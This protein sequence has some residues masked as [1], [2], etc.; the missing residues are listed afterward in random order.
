[1]FR[2]FPG[3][4]LALLVWLAA[5]PSADAV[6]AAPRKPNFVFIYTD[7]QRWDALGVV[8]REQGEQG[9]FPWLE[10]PNLDRLAAAGIRFRNAFVVNSLC[11]PSRATLLTGQYSHANG[12]VNN[13]EP[14]P[15]G[16]LSL[17]ALLR[18]AGYASAYIGKWHHGRE[19]GKRPGFDFSASFVGQGEYFDCPFEVDGVATP[20]TGFVDD[21]ATDY[22]ARFIR[23]HRADPFLLILGFKTCHKPFL[24]PPRR[25]LDYEGERARRTPNLDVRPTYKAAGSRPVTG[26]PT[27][28]EAADVPTNL[29]MF[30]GISA[31]DDNVG[32]LLDLLDDLGLADDTVVC[33]SSDNGFYLGEHGLGD[34]RS[35]YDE[36]LR[37]PLLVRYPRLVAAGRT[38]DRMVLN[39]DV[40]PTFLDLAGVPVPAAMHGRSWRPLLAGDR[41]APWRESFFYC[42]FYE[43]GFA[44]PTTTALRTAAAKL[45]VYPGH[46]DWT[47]VFDLAADPYETRNL[48]ADPAH[49]GLRKSLEAAYEE[50]SRAIGFHVPASVHTP[51]VDGV[52]PD[53]V[54][55]TP[56]KKSR[57]TSASPTR[58]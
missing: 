45:I 57:R 52:M 41:A 26:P 17:P 40:A 24:P 13:Q 36:A 31:I 18:P 1:M 54:K 2:R 48:A 10:T 35:A 12:V 16:N 29:G 32:R 56:P 22:A 47:E 44:T 3:S 51:P 39:V 49:A 38:E 30:R 21:V 23:D 27:S 8:Q 43:R 14:H 37:V 53:G 55:L 58:P 9:R 7:D 34:K 4:R 11:S 28:G 42:Y 15:P 20:T 19:S 33:F 46:D 6:A 25:E 5:M 50:Q